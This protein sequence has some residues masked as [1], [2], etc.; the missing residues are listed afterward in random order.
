M[1]LLKKRRIQPIKNVDNLKNICENI[2]INK[3]KMPA[4]V[5]DFITWQL[6]PYL[7]RLCLRCWLV[8]SITPDGLNEWLM[9]EVV[10]IKDKDVNMNLDML[11]TICYE[12]F[13]DESYTKKR[14]IWCYVFKRSIYSYRKYFDYIDDLDLTVVISKYY[15]I[16]T[17]QNLFMYNICKKCVHFVE[18]HPSLFGYIIEKTIVEQNYIVYFIELDAKL[19]TVP[20]QNC[21]MCRV[22]PLYTLLHIPFEHPSRLP[23]YEIYGRS[24][25][26]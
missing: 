7:V 1:K 22:Q 26:I 5:Y 12:D 25:T 6:P 24:R 8:N 16:E 3:I 13:E 19:Y 9:E 15:K 21:V 17:S 20:S 14:L 10:S 11:E 18:T 4:S 2:I 23:S